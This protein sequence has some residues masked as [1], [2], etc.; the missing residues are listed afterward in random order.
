MSRWIDATL[1]L[2]DGM[3]CWPGD[4]PFRRRELSSLER[5]DVA[6]VSS[7]SL[8]SHTGTH[9]DAPAHFIRGG[10]TVDQAPPDVLVGP[11]RVLDLAGR[12]A[13]D[14][15]DLEACHPRPGERLLLRTDNSARRASPSAGEAAVPVALTPA[16]AAL[17]AR[18]GV[19]LVGVDGL[20]VGREAD[21]VETHVVLLGAG[22][23]VLEGLDLADV[24]P[25][26]VDLVALPLRIVAGDGAP[27]RVLVRPVPS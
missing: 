16:A 25:G 1:P 9:L 26:P 10:L 4:P 22:I 23:W 17:L 11:G 6:A 2:H 18:R 15:A 19:A 5:G 14:E 3:A 21:G 27:C 12:P 8:S 13:V 20:S 24:P 7:L